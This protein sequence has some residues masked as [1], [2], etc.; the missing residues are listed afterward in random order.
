MFL[1]FSQDVAHINGAYSPSFNV[2]RQFFIG[3]FSGDPRWP[4]LGDPRGFGILISIYTLGSREAITI[5][6]R[7]KHRTVLA[8]Q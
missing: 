8:P 3:R 7:G 6:L 2:L 4:V 1:F 5:D